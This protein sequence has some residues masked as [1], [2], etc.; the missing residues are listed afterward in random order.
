M[1]LNTDVAFMFFVIYVKVKFINSRNPIIRE[2]GVEMLKGTQDIKHFLTNC[3]LNEV[4]LTA[5]R[6]P[7]LEDGA[8]LEGDM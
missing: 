3:M 1:S 6:T 4:Y 8:Y 7:C 2:R 5:V